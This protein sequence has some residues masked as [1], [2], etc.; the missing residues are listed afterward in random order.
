MNHFTLMLQKRLKNED[1]D[2]PDEDDK[3]SKKGQKNLKSKSFCLT[4]LSRHY[5]LTFCLYLLLIQLLFGFKI[6]KV[7][8]FRKK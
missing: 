1:D 7:F 3:K 8:I 4:N 2:D 5:T 6:K